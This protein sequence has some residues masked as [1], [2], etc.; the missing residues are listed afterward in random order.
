MTAI[1]DF[2]QHISAARARDLD[3]PSRALL[4]NH[5]VDTVGALLTGMH[6]AEGRALVRLL[7][8]DG[9]TLDA[10]ARRAAVT[11]LTEIDDI[12]L[13]SCTTP[14][15]VVVTAALTLAG[16]EK[17]PR[18]E[19][20]A[21]AVLAGY[22][23]MTR[24]GRVIEG[25]KVLYRG[26]WPTCF[27]TPFG[28]AAVAA[29]VAGL[30][31]T[32]TAHAVAMGMSEATPG[33]GR[34]VG[35]L[36]ARWLVLGEGARTGAS[37]ARA[38]AHGFSGDMEIAEGNWLK[39]AHGIES[40]PAA[41]TEGLGNGPALGAISL[42]PFCSAKQ[43]VGAVAGLRAILAR[44]IDPNSVTAVKVFVPEAYRVMISH[45]AQAGNR[46]SSILSVAYQLGL[47]AFEPDGLYDVARE[48]IA[49][50]GSV[51]EFA[52]KV[53]IAADPALA[54]HYPAR[55]PARIEVETSAGAASEEVLD[56]PGD[57][58]RP[59]D[60]AAVRD[61]FHRVADRFLGVQ[62]AE[63]WIA[64]AEAALEDDGALA[65]L[66]ALVSAHE[67]KVASA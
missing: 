23:A 59:L 60:A 30:D 55:W 35:P 26:V 7:P 11:R 16:G 61:K 2:A 48:H 31:A 39:G 17:R 18:A 63:E 51:V 28:A 13:S 9:G 67:A 47:A 65:E 64:M 43:S 52:K 8:S 33:P 14:G 42:K 57:P 53:S 56:A 10:V 34:P 21:D 25:P 38:A 66:A 36:A 19:A 46:S 29:R 58:G 32:K 50:D 24:L 44:G 27:A 12:H 49:S 40:N 54:A 41:L 45:A 3:A 1:Q 22:E 37:A 20:F 5:V 15:S 6:T 62:A 4:K